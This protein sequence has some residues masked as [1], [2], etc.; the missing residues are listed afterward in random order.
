MRDVLHW[1]NA[2]IPLFALRNASKSVLL[3]AFLNLKN[4]F[5]SLSHVGNVQ[6]LNW[7]ESKKSK[8]EG[9]C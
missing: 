2:V 4:V 7:Y 3:W 5:L 6:E 1:A 8:K 9:W